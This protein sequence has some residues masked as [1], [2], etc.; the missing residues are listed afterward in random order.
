[1]MPWEMLTRLGVGTVAGKSQYPLEN[2]GLAGVDT[3][4]AY[5][6]EV[7]AERSV[8]R[9][10]AKLDAEGAAKDDARRLQLAGTLLQ[11]Q[12]QKDMKAAALAN[13]PSAEDRRITRCSR[14]NW[15]RSNYERP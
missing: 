10:L 15:S 6:K 8:K 13:A 5:A 7:A 12:G 3:M 14:P 2:L 11:I 9:E 1:M 4:N